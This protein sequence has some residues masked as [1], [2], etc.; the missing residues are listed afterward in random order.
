MTGEIRPEPAVEPMVLPANYVSLEERLANPRANP[1]QHVLQ[2]ASYMLLHTE[3]DPIT[4]PE[5]VTQTW[6]VKAHVDNAVRYLESHTYLARTGQL[7][8]LDSGPSYPIFFSTPSLRFEAVRNLDLQNEMAIRD[9]RRKTNLSRADAMALRLGTRAV[10]WRRGED[11]V[12][13]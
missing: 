6:L 12:T 5:L 7:R 10:E 13:E 9:I 4:V 2:V 3:R 1:G 11:F 8:K